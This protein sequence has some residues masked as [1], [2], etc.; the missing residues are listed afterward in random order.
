MGE[1]PATVVQEVDHRVGLVQH[2]HPAGAQPQAAGL[3]RP[4]EVH[5]RVQLAG[6][7][8]ASAHAAG[9]DRLGLAALP[10][11]AGVLLDQFAAGD[12]QRQ[13]A[14]ARPVY[15]AAD[16]V[17]LRPVAAGVAGVVGVGRR[18]DRPEPIDAPLQD[19]L[20]AGQRLH[21]VHD[22]GLAEHALDGRERGLDP[23]PCPPALDALDQPRLLATDVG[24]R[25]AMDVNVQREV[26]AQD[27]LAQVAGPVALVDRRLHPLQA[28][29]VLVSQ[30]DVSGRR[31]GG[32]AA[33][34]HAFEDLV[35]VPLQLH[36][37]REGGRLALVGVDA[38]VDRPGMVLG[39]ERPLQ[40]GGEPGPAPPAEAAGADRLHHVGRRLLREH[41][42][43]GPV[44]AAGL[45]DGQRMA[46]GLVDVGQKYRFEVGHGEYRGQGSGIA[47]CRFA[48]VARRTF[49]LH[50]SDASIS[51]IF[52]LVMFLYSVSPAR[53]AGA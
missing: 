5:G 8:H 44:A 3:D 18:A 12:A 28:Q 9:H 41:L 34:D 7:E 22:G 48:A 50:S 26:A 47:A 19:V 1:E 14:V 42:L 46:V 10:H 13:L 29:G 20:H 45:V 24:R 30:V 51:S 23:R 4:A 43:Q 40:P 52:S 11:A 17:D 39:Q 16:P 21:V 31:P 35:R 32:V 37:V 2:D 27:V 33:Q 38:H 53:M 15:V 6:R 49:P 36:A 25:A